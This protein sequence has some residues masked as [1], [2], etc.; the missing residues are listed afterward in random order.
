MKRFSWLDVTSR[1][2]I[3]VVGDIMMDRYVRGRVNRISEEAPVPISIFES[4][5]NIL[6]GAAN[7]AA[8]VK[9]LGCNVYLSG[10]LGQDKTKDEVLNL[11]D[12]KNINRD[13]VF[14]R[15]NHYTTVKTRF[16]N[17]SQQIMRLDNEE[18]LKISEVESDNILL[19][20]ESLCENLNSVIISDYGKGVVSNELTCNIISLCNKRNIPVLIDPKGI[21]WEKYSNA[22]ALTPNVKELSKYCGYL[23]E[24][25]DESIVEAG[26]KIRKKL[27]L[28][29][30]IVTRSEK[31]ITCIG[32]NKIIHCPAFAKD[33]FDVSGA[34]DTVISIIA[35]AIACGVEM[36]EILEA[37]NIAASIAI[38]HVGTYQVKKSELENYCGDFKDF[39]SVFNQNEMD[40]F[41]KLI[42]K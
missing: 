20:L 1:I 10:M 4:S 17:N 16:L 29:Y 27:N 33:V 38:S 31:G 6:G 3:A 30:L 23:I 5:E 39:K 25:K 12:D 26:E 42:K 24:N 41:I 36:S 15:K 21:E 28:D 19:W 7:T 9:A 18:K 34:G 13:A 2:N 8:N 40:E 11:L 35:T 14:A 32:E 37:A 22:F